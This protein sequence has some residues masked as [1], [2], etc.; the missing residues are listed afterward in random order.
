MDGGLLAEC[1][2]DLTGEQVPSS[3]ENFYYV[4]KKYQAEPT[5]SR[6]FAQRRR[7]RPR[8]HRVASHFYGCRCPGDLSCPS[9][10]QR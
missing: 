9:S 4:Q 5:A 8:I 7:A 6:L 10:T 1:R 3:L 2:E